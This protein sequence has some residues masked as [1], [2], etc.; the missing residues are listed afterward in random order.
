M[1]EPGCANPCRLNN[2][3]SCVPFLNRSL[4]KSVTAAVFVTALVAAVPSGRAATVTSAN[5]APSSLEAGANANHAVVFTTGTGAIEGS[6]IRLEFAPDFDLSD[7]VEDDADMSVNGIA[8]TTAANCAGAEQVSVAIAGNVVTF[9]IC[10]GDGGAIAAGSEVAIDIGTQAADSGIGTNQIV[11]PENP[12]TYF[13]SIAGTFGD[14][15][16]IALP[17]TSDGAVAV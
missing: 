3:S 1:P 10:A 17:I 4:W 6:T 16:S 14:S 11:N 5:D 12:G 15:G 13:V 8:R 9:T 2:R 7:I